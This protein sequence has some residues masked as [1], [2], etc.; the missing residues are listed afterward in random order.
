MRKKIAKDISSFCDIKNFTSRRDGSCPIPRGDAAQVPEDQGEKLEKLKDQ[1]DR[2]K[3]AWKIIRTIQTIAPSDDDSK[4]KGSLSDYGFTI[5]SIYTI[6]LAIKS[7][8]ESDLKKELNNEIAEFKEDNPLDESSLSDWR[9]FFIS[10][11]EFLESNFEMITLSPDI[12]KM[13][14]SVN[15]KDPIDT[16]K[17]EV[18]GCIVPGQ[19]CAICD[20]LEDCPVPEHICLRVQKFGLQMRKEIAGET[21]LED[22]PGFDPANFLHTREPKITP[23]A[24]EKKER[25]LAKDPDKARKIKEFKDRAQKLEERKDKEKKEE[26]N[27]FTQTVQRKQELDREETYPG[28][29]VRDKAWDRFIAELGHKP[30]DQQKVYLK[31]FVDPSKGGVMIPELDKEGNPI[32]GKFVKLTVN[33]ENINKED[34]KTLLTDPRISEEYKKVQPEHLDKFI[35]KNKSKTLG[36]GTQMSIQEHGEAMAKEPKQQG[37]SD[38]FQDVYKDESVGI[39]K[40]KPGTHE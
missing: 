36:K 6:G 15:H 8:P 25:E 4:E 37:L 31:K 26:K 39:P 32:K 33:D 1:I 21:P 13:Y 5:P 24:I 12:E 35:E 23:A 17:N 9:V 19:C 3:D 40:Q 29:T 20:H 7:L 16:Y 30:E 22:I 2:G 10:I 38:I 18:A 11:R 28:I 14:A 34:L 27:P